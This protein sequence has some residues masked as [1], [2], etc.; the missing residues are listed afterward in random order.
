MM[1]NGKYKMV[2]VSWVRPMSGFTLLF[3]AYMMMLVESEMSVAAVLKT[4][5]GNG[6]AYLAYVPPLS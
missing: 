1:S 2:G 5:L 4:V 3:E 6:S